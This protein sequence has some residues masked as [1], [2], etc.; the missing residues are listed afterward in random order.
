MNVVGRG[1]IRYRSLAWLD[2]VLMVIG[3]GCR[4]SSALFHLSCVNVNATM[5]VI[6]GEKQGGWISWAMTE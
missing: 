3:S 4:V 6:S 1:G 5:G 2:R